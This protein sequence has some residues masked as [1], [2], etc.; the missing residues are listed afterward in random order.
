MWDGSQQTIETVK[1]GDQVM[2]YDGSEGLVTDV[3][4][5]ESDHVLELRYLELTDRGNGL[6]RR[7]ETTDEHLFWVKGE[8][9][10]VSGRHL[11]EGDLLVMP[12]GKEAEITEIWRTENSSTVYSFDVEG[13]NTFYV[14][15]VLVHQKCGG[16]EE[17]LVEERLREYL[18]DEGGGGMTL[19]EEDIS[20]RG[21]AS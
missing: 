17:T 2:A 4:V 9:K 20:E 21:D 18:Y 5:R 11:I 15:G 3:Y 19:L 12:D 13:Y 7:L 10:W 14:N 8:K 6:L 1:V 16:A